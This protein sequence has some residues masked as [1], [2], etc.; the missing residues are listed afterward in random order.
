MSRVDVPPLN[1]KEEKKGI[2]VGL[3]GWG[4]LQILLV[5]AVALFYFKQP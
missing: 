5:F 2:L 3:V 1:I 4:E